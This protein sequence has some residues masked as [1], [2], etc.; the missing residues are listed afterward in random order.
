MFPVLVLA[1]GRGTRLDPLTR[2]VAKPAV[3]LGGKTLI[4]RILTGLRQHG[5]TDV[6]INLHHRAETI[7]AITGDGASL[8]V[9]IR[10][11]WE[12]EVLG[13]AGG[14]RHALPLLGTET[15]FIVNG[16]TLTDVALAPLVGAHRR[17]R[18]AVTLAL[19]RQPAPDR[20][21]GLLLDADHDVVGVVPKGLAAHTWHYVGVQIAQATV[22]AD[23]ED[24][25]HAE[26]IGGIYRGLMSGAAG[27]LHGFAAETPFLDVG[28]PRDYLT[29]AL[30]ASRAGPDGAAI[31]PGADVDASARLARTVVWP[32]AAVGPGADLE[33]CIVAGPVRV[34]G[35]MRVR[36]A[37]LVPESVVRP[38]DDVEV[39]EG[40]AIFP[41]AGAPEDGR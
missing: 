19:M 22:F 23:L 7:T 4:E 10:Y 40:V 20:Y 41:L 36:H 37:A 35:G 9:S 26:S 29:A 17:S 15:F 25:V 2:L 3:P 27:R 30:R 11:S 16:D 14:P 12:P 8:N 13:S 1:A 31:E 21:S 6:V 32:D 34:P 28:T 18:A 5:I 38:D 24:G 39:R 33:D